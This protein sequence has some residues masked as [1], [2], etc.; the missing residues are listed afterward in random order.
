MEE[1][2][3]FTGTH[4]TINSILQRETTNHILCSALVYVSSFLLQEALDVPLLP[5]TE[6]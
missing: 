2:K 1:M 3:S 5:L 6:L 4:G